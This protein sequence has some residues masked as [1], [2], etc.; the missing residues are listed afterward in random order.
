MFAKQ[1]VPKKGM[2]FVS[3]VL[4]QRQLMGLSG[5]IKSWSVFSVGL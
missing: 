4:R 2:G 1:C 3:S 5:T